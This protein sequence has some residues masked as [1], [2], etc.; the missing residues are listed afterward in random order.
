MQL[1]ALGQIALPVSDPDRA[2]KF[3]G[4]ELGLRFLFRFGR[5]VFFDCAGV[6]LLLEGPPHEAPLRPSAGCLYF[7]VPHIETAY[8]ELRHQHV[9]FDGAPHLIAKM[10][11]HDLWMAFFKDPDGHQ[12]A[13]MDEK[14]DAKPGAKPGSP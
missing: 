5:L 7:K 6:R 4:E 10:P 2:Q 13:I 8:D 9:E 14:R 12:L 3:Y 11:D 1:S